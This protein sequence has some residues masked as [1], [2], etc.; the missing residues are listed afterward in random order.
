MVLLIMIIDVHLRLE[1]TV[2]EIGVALGG[3]VI[4]VATGDLLLEDLHHQE[5]GIA[6]I[7]PCVEDLGRQSGLGLDRLSSAGLARQLEGSH[8]VNLR[9]LNVVVVP[10]HPRTPPVPLDR[11]PRRALPVLSP[12]PDPGTATQRKGTNHWLSPKYLLMSRCYESFWV[13]M[14]GKA[15][16]IYVLVICCV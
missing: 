5:D 3:I 13:I 11:T 12:G 14:L 7:R 8:D 9:R 2:T 16:Q 1:A 6:E 15:L 10:L 4:E